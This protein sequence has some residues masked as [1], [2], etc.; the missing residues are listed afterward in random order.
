MNALSLGPIT[1]N[2]AGL[3][4]PRTGR[5][6]SIRTASL[7]KQSSVPQI[8]PAGSLAGHLGRP[9]IESLAS[10]AAPL[11]TFRQPLPARAARGRRCELPPTVPGRRRQPTAGRPQLPARAPPLPV[12]CRSR[13]RRLSMR[14][15]TS[16]RPN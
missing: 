3:V 8:S 12:S 1:A 9:L 10:A 6:G 7:S 15:L 2:T 16:S 5:N 11:S 14:R 4:L 13:Y